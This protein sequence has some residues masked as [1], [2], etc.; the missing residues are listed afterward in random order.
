MKTTPRSSSAL[1]N[2]SMRRTLVFL[3]VISSYIAVAFGANYPT[4]GQAIEWVQPDGTMI[5]L[6]VFG[7]EFY[8]RTATDS[9]YTVIFE[10]SDKSYYYAVFGPDGKS[11]VRS[12]VA[13]GKPLPINLSKNIEEP[14][15]V[16]AFK[17]AQNI[18]RFAP[19][20]SSDWAA[21]KKSVQAARDPASPTSISPQMSNASTTKRP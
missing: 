7:D 16:V 2:I 17:R 13:V 9:G 11:L 3:A 10:A 14:A 4:E 18:E 8:A 12:D 15:D 21:R 1:A 19:E 6:R 20:R 5:S